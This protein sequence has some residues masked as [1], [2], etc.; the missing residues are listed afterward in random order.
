M[1]QFRSQSICVSGRGKRSIFKPC[2]VVGTEI[3]AEFLGHGQDGKPTADDHKRIAHIVGATNSHEKLLEACRISSHRAEQ[4]LIQL[5]ETATPIVREWL[6]GVISWN[7]ATITA[8]EC[9]TRNG[10]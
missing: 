7:K 6:E 10:V 3:V 4:A 1:D 8:A 5:G 9:R 2:L